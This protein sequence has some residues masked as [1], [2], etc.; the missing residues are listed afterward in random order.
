MT[1]GAPD[2]DSPQDVSIRGAA[3][4]A[5]NAWWCGGA[6]RTAGI[7]PAGTGPRGPP[8]ARCFARSPCARAML[9]LMAVGLYFGL[10]RQDIAPAEG[11]LSIPAIASPAVAG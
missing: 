6:A 1:P 10:A 9:V 4:C 2:V 8:A 11:S 3:S 5:A 7:A